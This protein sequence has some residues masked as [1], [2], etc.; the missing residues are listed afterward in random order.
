MV[1]TKCRWARLSCICFSSMLLLEDVIWASNMIS[2]L[3]Y[4]KHFKAFLFFLNQVLNSVLS[5]YSCCK[6][7]VCDMYFVGAESDQ[8]VNICSFAIRCD[9]R[10]PST[11]LHR[12]YTGSGNMPYVQLRL[13]GDFILSSGARSLLWGYKR[14]GM[15][16]EVLEAQSNSEPSG[17]EW[18]GL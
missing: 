7:W 12:V 1:V 5:Y 3:C 17:P 2:N 8:H 11:Q 16:R 9:R 15:R 10:W 6:L 13:V 18:R 14:I 4:C